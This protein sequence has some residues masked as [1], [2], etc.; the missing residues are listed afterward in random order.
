MFVRRAI[1]SLDFVHRPEAKKLPL[2]IITTPEFLVLTADRALGVQ[3]V[4]AAVELMQFEL[5]QPVVVRA[6]NLALLP[7]LFHDSMRLL[8]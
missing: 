7:E 1:Q 3:F 2:R 5:E 6:S 4:I 8:C